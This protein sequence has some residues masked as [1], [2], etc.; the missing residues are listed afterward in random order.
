MEKVLQVLGLERNVKKGHWDPTTDIHHLGCG[1]DTRRGTYYVI[2]EKQQRLRKF[3]ADLL[4]EG[5]RQR[6]LIPV[7]KLASFAGLAQSVIL[8]LPAARLF[9][10]SLHDCVSTRT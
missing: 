2:H 5:S 6:Q 7:R 1:I 10:R 8:A 9:L 4:G 3:A